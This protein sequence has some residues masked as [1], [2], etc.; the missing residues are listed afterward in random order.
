MTFSTIMKTRKPHL[1]NSNYWDLPNE[2][3]KYIIKDAST[4]ARLMPD[5]SE[6]SK[7]LDQVNDACTV[8][9]YRKRV[10]LAS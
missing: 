10:W 7:W 6:T 9:Y 1:E 5:C 2:S 8:L 4:A 3:L